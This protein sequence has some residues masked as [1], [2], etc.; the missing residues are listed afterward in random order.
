MTLKALDAAL[1]ASYWGTQHPSRYLR[2][3]R[4]FVALLTAAY[5]LGFTWGHSGPPEQRLRRIVK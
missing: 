4:R 3:E 1:W 2:E 5:K